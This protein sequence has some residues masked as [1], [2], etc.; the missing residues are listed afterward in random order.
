MMRKKFTGAKKNRGNINKA[1]ENKPQLLLSVTVAF[2]TLRELQ[3]IFS[4]YHLLY[5]K[6]EGQ[7]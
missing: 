1:I 5:S 6:R 2:R 4:A 3:K 7:K